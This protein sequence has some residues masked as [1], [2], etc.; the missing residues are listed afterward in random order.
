M[1]TFISQIYQKFGLKLREIIFNISCLRRDKSKD[2][3]FD[4]YKQKDVYVLT[5]KHCLYIASLIENGLKKEGINSKIIFESPK[6]GFGEGLHFVVCPQM[7]AFLPKHYVAYQLEQS[8]SSR[9]FTPNYL[10]KLNYAYKVFDYSIENIK[11]LEN[12]GINK[13]NLYFMPISYNSGYADLIGK[14]N[15]EYDVLFY[16]DS[17]NTRRKRYLNSLAEN[18]N[19][20]IVSN[21][22]G[23]ELY[24]ELSKAKIIINIHYYDGALLET[25]RLYECLSLN[26]FIISE[27]SP[28]IHNHSELQPCIEFVE[29]N[30]IQGMREKV[31]YWLQ[32]DTLRRNRVSNNKDYLNHNL[33]NLFDKYFS[34]FLKEL[35]KND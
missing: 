7:F 30:D 2:I 28:D 11:Y 10:K 9:W 13:R 17:S 35:I 4:L 18:F 22:F 27:T 5:T 15:E 23:E 25:T 32:N 19:I 16:G 34:L 3:S 29:I 33:N 12:K 8:V 1:K 31:N 26:K 24:K 14:E 21:L 6:S 20:R